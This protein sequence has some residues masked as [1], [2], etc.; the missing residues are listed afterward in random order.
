MY[1]GIYI[2]VSGMVLRD[3][4]IDTIAQNLANVSTTGYK[5]DD[6]AFEDYLMDNGATAGT[7]GDGRTMAQMGTV[8]TDF[9]P[10]EMIH[11]GSP[12]DLAISGDG[13][14]TVEGDLYTRGGNFTLDDQG[15]IVDQHGHQLQGQG[16]AINVGKANG[17]IDIAPDGSVSVGGQLIDTIKVVKFDNPTTLTRAGSG[18]F[19]SPTPPQTVVETP[20]IK[21]GFLESSNVNAISEMMKMITAQREFESFQGVISSFDTSASRITNDLA[22]G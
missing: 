16:G 6:V 3:R 20:D 8:T 10:G 17:S 18:Y 7:V 21:Q 4:A 11:T 2:A 15:N 14:F 19:K 13:F 9:T 1:K 22:R 12:L 5:R